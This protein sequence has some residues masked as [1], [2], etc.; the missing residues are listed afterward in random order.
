MLLVS[1][2]TLASAVRHHD[3]LVLALGARQTVLRLR[4][5]EA[6]AWTGAAVSLVQHVLVLA[7]LAAHCRH[8]VASVQTRQAV[9]RTL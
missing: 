6:V 2:L 1:R 5:L 4:T 8:T 7:R 9:E 3:G